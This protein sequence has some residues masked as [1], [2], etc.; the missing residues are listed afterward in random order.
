MR[1]TDFSRRPPAVA[2]A[3]PTTPPLVA[4]GLY[5]PHTAPAPVLGGTAG[6]AAA[7]ACGEYVLFGNT[8]HH[9]ARTTPT[10]HADPCSGGAR[11]V[12]VWGGPAD[13]GGLRLLFD[14]SGGDGR[15][16]IGTVPAAG[17]GNDAGVDLTTVIAA[18]GTGGAVLV[19][20]PRRGW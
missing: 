2:I 5:T 20:N 17:W 18:A 8:G 10:R 11:G 6:G 15:W 13:G 9:V 7:A 19:T 4:W 12:G 14:G 16:L 1:A 3:C